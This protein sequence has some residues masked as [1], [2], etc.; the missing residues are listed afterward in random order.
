MTPKNVHEI[1]CK[2][3]DVKA[4]S[5]FNLLCVK[6]FLIICCFISDKKK[7]MRKYIKP[8]TVVINTLITKL[9]II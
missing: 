6:T 1:K 8:T 4:S 5:Y 3:S 2:S 7:R 9:L